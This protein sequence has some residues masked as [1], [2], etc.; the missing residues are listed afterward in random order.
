MHVCVYVHKLD[1][2][3]IHFTQDW[4]IRWYALSYLTGF[5]CAYLIMAAL[6]RRGRVLLRDKEQAADFIMYCVVGTMLGGRLGYAILYQ[7][8]LFVEFNPRVPFWELLAIHHGGMASHGGM[9]G[10]AIACGLYARKYKLPVRHLFDLIALTG[11]IGIFFGRLANFVNGEMYGRPAGPGTPWVV[12]FPHEMENWGLEKLVSL[13]DALAPLGIEGGSD[14]DLVTHTMKRIQQSDE[15][16]TQAVAPLLTARHPSQIYEALLE[17]VLLFAVLWLIWRVPRKPGVVGA[18]FL[19]V[20]AVLRIIGEQFRTP[21]A[22]IGFQALG[23]TR[24]QWLSLV[25]LVIGIVLLI[26]WSKRPATK[27]GGWSARPTT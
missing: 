26:L 17:G 20:Y 21:D 7:P 6:A 11:P 25:M 13:R 3:A 2:I 27:I 24:G 8:A 9:V 4:G 12:K 18:W 15:P 10:L 19:V 14:Q 1:P 22:H 23:L 5:L 16:V